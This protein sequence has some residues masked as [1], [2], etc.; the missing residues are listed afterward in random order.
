MLAHGFTHVE[1]LPI[2]EH[3]FYGSW[4]YQ[5]TGYF[6]PTARYGTPQDLMAMVDRLHQ[7]GVGVILDWVPSHFPMDAHGLARFDGTHLYEHADPRQGYHPDWTSAIFNYGR[8]EVRSFL[9]SSALCWLDRYH[10]DG[11]RVDAVAS[12]LYL[13]YS[14][15]EGEWIPNRFG[16]R[17]NLEAIDFLRQ[18]NDAIDEEFPDVATFAE[19]STAWPMVTGSTAHGGLGFGYKWDMG[20]MHDTLQYIRRDPVHRRFHHDEVTFRSVYAFTERY[21]MPLSHDEVVHGKGSLLGKMP[22]DDWQ[23]FANLRLLLR[24]DVG[25]AR[26]EAAVHGRRA[27]DVAGVEPRRDARLEPP[28]RAATTTA[29]GCGS[30]RS[31]SC[32]AS[33]PALSR[34]DCDPAGFRWIIGDDD[35]HSV[36]AWLRTRPDR[37]GAAGAGGRQ[38]H[39]DGA[40]RLPHRR[41][42]PAAAGSSC[43]TPTPRST[44]AAAWATSAP[45]TPRTTR[46]TASSSRCR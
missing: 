31:T 4:G 23:R 38:R 13:D 25:P 16:G 32:T 42:R 12:M 24:D 15:D 9:I 26:Q 34:G 17:E 35:T 14:R 37:R 22:G 40:L 43:S 10:V 39:A 1:L 21:V 11:L 29:C 28:R 46:G 30:P 5:T 8:R 27:G 19:E 3:P 2:M 45:S 20:W 36:F 6:A 7:R 41:A 33:E 44:A 18:L